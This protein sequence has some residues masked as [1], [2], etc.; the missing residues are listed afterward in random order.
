MG[1]FM[2]APVDVRDQPGPAGDSFTHDKKSGAS[3][4]TLQQ[5]QNARR[6]LG[7]R[8]I[9]NRQSDVRL[10][11]SKR[12]DHP[13][14]PLARWHKQMVEDKNIGPE[15]KERAH[16]TPWSPHPP[17]DSRDLAKNF[18]E[19]EN[20]CHWFYASSMTRS[21]AIQLRPFA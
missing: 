13:G 21:R 18:A 10:I 12:S 14:E 17:R 19:E 2:T 20:A 8:T 9:V 4:V 16:R 7:I 15:K 5:F 11:C 1:N 3:T 6:V